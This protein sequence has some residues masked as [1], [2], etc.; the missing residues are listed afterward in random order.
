[1]RRDDDGARRPRSLGDHRMLTADPLPLR[2]RRAQERRMRRRCEVPVWA[3]WLA[4]VAFCA[5]CWGA[6]AW[7]VTR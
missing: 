2:L 4:A 7:L 6:V 1:M 3:V 5:A